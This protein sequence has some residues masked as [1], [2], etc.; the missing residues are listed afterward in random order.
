MDLVGRKLGMNGGRPIQAFGAE[1]EGYLRQRASTKVLVPHVKALS[2]ALGDLRQAALW[3][4]KQ[5]ASDPDALGAGSYD[6]LNLFSLVALGYM[7]CRMTEAAAAKLASAPSAGEAHLR[8][9]LVVG[10]F[11]VENMLPE[12]AFLLSRIKT[13]ADTV[14]GLP[15]EAF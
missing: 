6:F 1:V 15:A 7:W 5:G 2:A 12:T 14:M 13:G 4:V 11:F 9:K 3:L 10:R 8:S